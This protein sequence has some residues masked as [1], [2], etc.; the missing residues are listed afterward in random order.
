VGGGFFNDG[1]ILS[2]GNVDDAEGPN[3]SDNT[4]TDF[5]TPGD[6]ELDTLAGDDTFDAAIFE[7]D[8]TTAGGDL[9]F[10]YR[11]ASEEYN[12][13]VDSSFN[14]VFGFFLDGT[15]IAKIPGTNDP[16][17]VNNVNNTTNSS[18]FNDND[19]SDTGTPFD[20][21]YDGFT[22]TFSAGATGLSSGSHLLELKVADTSDATYDSAVFI[23]SGT[24]SDEPGADIPIPSTVGLFL[25]GLAG[26]GLVA[27]CRR[28]SA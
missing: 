12:E 22:D 20:I 4:S 23:Q 10:N 14:D 15:N 17:S 26:L 13:F 21:E 11:F 5:G 9:F 19:P 3:D 2:S 1:I 18:F 6:S 16:V 8:F 27:R 24:L 28:R 25:A 7:I